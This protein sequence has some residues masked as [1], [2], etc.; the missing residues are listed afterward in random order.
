VAKNRTKI[1]H[2][3]ASYRFEKDGEIFNES[4][5]TEV[6]KALVNWGEI[7]RTLNDTR[8]YEL[9]LLARRYI[10]MEEKL[11]ERTEGA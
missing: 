8:A 4:N 3:F 2:S 7:P 9:A 11:K 10:D 1:K 6:A 5:L